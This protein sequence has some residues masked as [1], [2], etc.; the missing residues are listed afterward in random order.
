MVTPNPHSISVSVSSLVCCAES[1]DS[2]GDCDDDSIESDGVT[3][4]TELD[5]H[6]NM[7]VVGKNA[8]VIQFTG[9]STHVQAFSPD[10]EPQ[11]VKIVDALVMW[12]DPNNDKSCLPL[13]E[14]ALHVPSMNDNLVPP[15][16]IREAGAVCKDVPKIH[17]DK[18]DSEDHTLF[19]PD[20]EVRMVSQLNGTFSCFPTMSP[21]DGDIDRIINGNE[22][23]PLLLT[24]EHA[25]DPHSDMHAKNEF[26]VT[27]DD[28]NL[29]HASERQQMLLAD[30]PQCSAMNAC[31]C[32]S[33]HESSM[34]DK[35]FEKVEPFF[36]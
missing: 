28:G 16:L 21:T 3:S 29:K 24:P 14:N 9:K 25:V 36:Q 19:F 35:V 34:I 26:N 2:H 1:S 15:F 8:K 20:R 13:I 6:A 10:C 12:E 5:S 22:E 30:M 4:R 27:D 23:E 11:E 33:K 17:V 7:A 31:Q 32:I 18:P